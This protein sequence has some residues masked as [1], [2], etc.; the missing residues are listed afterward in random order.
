M[1]RVHG[2]STVVVL[3]LVLGVALLGLTL[4]AV[5]SPTVTKAAV[6]TES[7]PAGDPAKI[8]R[9]GSAAR[10]P[11]LDM[12]ED[13]SD[14][15]VRA[16][17]E[18]N[19]QELS[20]EKTRSGNT[21]AER[22]PPPIRTPKAEKRISELRDERRAENR[23][24]RA[25]TRGPATAAEA[26]ARLNSPDGVDPQRLDEN[27][28]PPKGSVLS[29]LS[30]ELLESL[31]FD[32]SGNEPAPQQDSARDYRLVVIDHVFGSVAKTA[33]IELGDEITSYF[34]EPVRNL[35]QLNALMELAE[36]FGSNR[37]DV[38]VKRTDGIHNLKIRPGALGLI[39][40]GK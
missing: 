26:I 19:P 1:R 7:I 38:Q 25:A 33:G 9:L 22:V 17:G 24:R 23:A 18:P 8:R 29:E 16:L 4:Y 31:G 39:I 3:A 10:E 11:N 32:S 21:S 13:S 20:P 30:P 37:I 2:V 35:D 12:L 5:R 6:D 27:W 40:Q 28:I 14:T 34:G 36:S 15:V